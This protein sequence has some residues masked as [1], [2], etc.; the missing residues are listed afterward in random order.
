MR[1]TGHKVFDTSL[2]E[3]VL[4]GKVRLRTAHMAGTMLAAAIAQP[5]NCA[6]PE[7]CSICRLNCVMFKS[8]TAWAS[9]EL[10]SKRWLV[11]PIPCPASGRPPVIPGRLSN[12][13]CP[14]RDQA[15]HSSGR[16][17]ATSGRLD[18]QNASSV[19]LSLLQQPG[20][21]PPKPGR[22]ASTR[23][24]KA[25]KTPHSPGSTSDPMLGLGCGQKS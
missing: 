24:R 9:I 10:P 17:P 12:Q 2:G 14:T 7:I 23:R 21:L 5:N 25:E 3:F 13:R 4:K 20:S 16:L 11:A 8:S 18:S 6:D 22:F 15:P 19:G 1:G